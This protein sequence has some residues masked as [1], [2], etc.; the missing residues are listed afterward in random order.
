MT[1]PVPESLEAQLLLWL[2]AHS[3]EL[4]DRVFVVSHDTGALRSWAFVVLA[5]ALCHRRRGE[6][7]AARLWL[8]LGLTTLVLQEGLKFAIQRP[9]PALWPQ[10]VS[11]GGFSFPSGHALAAATFC[12]M[13][14]WSLSLLVPRLRHAFWA[15]ALS[16]ALW[17]ALG[18]LYLGVH[19]PSDVLAGLAL[20]ALQAAVALERSRRRRVLR[21]EGRR[22]GGT[23]RT[24][25]TT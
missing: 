16:I 4:L 5:F 9:R 3:S 6:R 24:A 14:A 25:S 10:L 2:H 20:G 22:G 17:I 11:P 18:R 21:C 19:W 1:P 15:V 12:P 7:A 13:L 8:G 23:S